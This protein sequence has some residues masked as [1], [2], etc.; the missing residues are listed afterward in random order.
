LALSLLVLALLMSSAEQRV[1]AWNPEASDLPGTDSSSNDYDGKSSNNRFD[2][3]GGTGTCG[4]QVGMDSD[5]I[6]FLVKLDPGQSERTRFSVSQMGNGDQ[7]EVYFTIGEASFCMLFQATGRKEGVAKLYKNESGNWSL[8][9][10]LGV[11]NIK[12]GSHYNDASYHIGFTLTDA[13]TNSHG[14][15]KFVI[16]RHRL[17]ELGARG[18]LVSY[19]YAATRSNGTG[20]PGSGTQMDRCPATGTVTWDLGE[21]IPDLPLGALL[22]VFPLIALYAYLRRSRSGPAHGL[23]TCPWGPSKG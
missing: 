14:S 13:E 20:T 1:L 4:L 5:S 18:S 8:C 10:S 15:V 12:S 17:Y 3:S 21:E 22:L 6:A 2:I 7:Y 19:I 9:N 11:E 23:G 16:N